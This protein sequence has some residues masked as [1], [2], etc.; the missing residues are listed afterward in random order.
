MKELRRL[1]EYAIEQCEQGISTL[2]FEDSFVEMLDYVKH[3]SELREQA[4]KLFMEALSMSPTPWELMSFCMHELRWQAVR[5]RAE[6]LR[7]EASDPR[8]ERIFSLILEAFQSDWDGREMY[9][10]AFA[11]KEA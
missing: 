4:E 10:Y 11:K 7:A 3:H 6:A 8:V 2:D 9:S 5:D 1:F